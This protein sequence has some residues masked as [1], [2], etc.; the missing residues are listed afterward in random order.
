M[1]YDLLISLIVIGIT[2]ISIGIWTAIDV[3]RKK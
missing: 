2:F 3:L 1:D